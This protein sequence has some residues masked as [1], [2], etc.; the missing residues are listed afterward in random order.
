MLW[1]FDTVEEVL[2]LADRAN[3]NSEHPS[4]HEVLVEMLQSL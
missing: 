4:E 3:V 2:L 1:L